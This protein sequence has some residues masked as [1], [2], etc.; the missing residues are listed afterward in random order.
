MS[1]IWNPNRARMSVE[2]KPFDVPE[3]GWLMCTSGEKLCFSEEGF[4]QAYQSWRWGH[5]CLNKEPNALPLPTFYPCIVY[6]DETPG[7]DFYHI[8]R[9]K[10]FQ[11]AGAPETAETSKPSILW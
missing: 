10:H 2:E 4:N 3:T 9:T 11:I 1:S 8:A 6:F 7:R 5:N